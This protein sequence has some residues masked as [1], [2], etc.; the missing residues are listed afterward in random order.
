MDLLIGHYVCGFH[1]NKVNVLG[2]ASVCDIALSM[3]MT[4]Y[5]ISL[6]E[7]ICIVIARIMQINPHKCRAVQFFMYFIF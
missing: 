1:G 5:F 7:G 3:L 4:N 2:S 6:S